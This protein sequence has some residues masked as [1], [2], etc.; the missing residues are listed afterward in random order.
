MEASQTA[1]AQPDAPAE[2]PAQAPAEEGVITPSQ[3]AQQEQ[4]TP[5]L[6]QIGEQIGALQ[7]RFDSRFPDQEDD[8]PAGD[9]WDAL[10]ADDPAQADPNADDFDP[11]EF[12][13]LGM[14]QPAPMFESQQQLDQYVQNKAAEVLQPYAFDQ[15]MKARAAKLGDLEKK[16]DDIGGY[17]DQIKSVLAPRA[18]QYGIDPQFLATDPALVEAVYKGLKADEA[19][20]AEVDANEASNAG[21]SLETGTGPGS[22]GSEQDPGEAFANRFAEMTEGHVKDAFS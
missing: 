21:A 11:N 3:P 2:E 10:N 17:A 13:D 16:Y 15:E 1:P 5:D 8:Q 9:F 6:S 18:E 4:A 19:S 12:G 20:S 14:E 7:E 22:Q